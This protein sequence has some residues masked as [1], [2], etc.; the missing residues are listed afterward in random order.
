MTPT[1]RMV[2]GKAGKVFVCRADC[3]RHVVLVP[4]AVVVWHR[5]TNT[6][7]ETRADNTPAVRTMKLRLQPCTIPS[8]WHKHHQHDEHSWHPSS[9]QSACWVLEAA[10][11]YRGLID[12]YHECS[13]LLAQY[14]FWKTQCQTPALRLGSLS[15]VPGDRAVHPAALLLEIPSQSLGRSLW[16]CGAVSE[17]PF[18]FSS[19]MLVGWNPS[20]KL[21][22]TV[23]RHKGEQKP[24]GVRKQSNAIGNFH[25]YSHLHHDC[26]SPV[27]LVAHVVKCFPLKSW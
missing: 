27:G 14:G 9:T 23:P 4:P 10:G 25:R 12:H 18:P 22:S 20:S 16:F 7:Y 13:A 2:G 19:R 17:P 3:F 26:H 6:T 24:R 5:H 21:C 15:L 1:T 11:E 8:R